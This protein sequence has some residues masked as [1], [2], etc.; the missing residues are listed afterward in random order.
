MSQYIP[1]KKEM[2]DRVWKRTLCLL[3][4]F[5]SLKKEQDAL[6]AKL[7]SAKNTPAN[8]VVMFD[9]SHL[10]ELKRQISAIEYGFSTIENEFDR[11]VIYHHLIDKSKYYE[12]DVPSDSCKKRIKAR[13]IHAIAKQLGEI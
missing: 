4:D 7:Y 8:P 6:N 13:V 3:E 5:K 10:I 9:C 2:P 1:K 12:I 11:N